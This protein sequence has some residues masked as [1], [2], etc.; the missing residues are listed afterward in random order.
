MSPREPL[1]IV[2]AGCS[3]GHNLIVEYSDG[4]TAIYLLKQ[5][6]ELEPQQTFPADSQLPSKE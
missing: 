3:K 6:L 1:R 4:T 5:L 2:G